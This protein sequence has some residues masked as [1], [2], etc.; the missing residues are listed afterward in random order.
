MAEAIAKTTHAQHELIRN[1]ESEV[2]AAD[3]AVVAADESVLDAYLRGPEVD[4]PMSHVSDLTSAAAVAM[5]P[6]V[7]RG[8]QLSRP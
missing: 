7:D 4:N 2:K 5:K 3:E 6:V 8:K 1:L